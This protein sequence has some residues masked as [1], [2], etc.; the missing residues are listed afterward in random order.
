[1]LGEKVLDNTNKLNHS[2]TDDMLTN[3]ITEGLFKDKFA[4]LKK[5]LE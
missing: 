3:M 4:D 5:T 1:M 2:P